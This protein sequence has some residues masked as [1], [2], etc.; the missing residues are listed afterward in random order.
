MNDKCCG[1]N[2]F[3]YTKK[4]DVA[5]GDREEKNFFYNENQ[6]DQGCSPIKFSE[7]KSNKL[8]LKKS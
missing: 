3:N 8:L 6:C 1:Q 7:L 2:E 5:I 4:V